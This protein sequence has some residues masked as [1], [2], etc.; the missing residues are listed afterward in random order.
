MKNVLK[1]A[2]SKRVGGVLVLASLLSLPFP[3]ERTVNTFIT[4]QIQKMR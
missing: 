3:L 4:R 1:L 2:K